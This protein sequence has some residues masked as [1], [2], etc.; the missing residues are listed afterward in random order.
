MTVD[1]KYSLLSRGNLMLPIHMQLSQ[2]RK[3]FLNNFPHFGNLEW[4]KHIFNKRMSLITDVFP[5][6]LTPKNV[7]RLMFKKPR[8]RGS[9]LKQY[10][11]WAQTLLKS[12]RQHLYQKYL[13]MWRQLSCKTS[14]LVMCKILRLFVNTSAADEKYYL[15]NREKLT[16]R[17]HIQLSQKQ[18][19]FFHCF[20]D[21]LKSR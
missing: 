12:A 14:L 11:K 9:F 18:K 15:L 16:H 13:S 3:A 4:I 5:K 17:I 8:F 21:L 2:K 1:A 7:V 20:S 10:G 19:T 6:L